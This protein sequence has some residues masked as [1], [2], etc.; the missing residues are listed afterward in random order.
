M[1]AYFADLGVDDYSPY[2]EYYGMSYLMQSMLFNKV[3][4][5]AA[6]NAVLAD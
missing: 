2:E 6:D 3:V 1:E 5:F 4:S